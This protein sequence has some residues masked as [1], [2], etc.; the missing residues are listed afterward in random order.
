MT[1][2]AA[3][4]PAAAAAAATADFATAGAAGA[5][6][7]GSTGA[8]ISAVLGGLGSL[9]GLSAA[10]LPS[11]VQAG[12]LRALERAESMLIAARSGVLAAF[13]A[14]A[15]YQED[16]QYSARAWLTAQTRVTR[17]GGWLREMDAATG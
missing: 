15:G 9:A 7:A 2:P 12:C 1:G 4:G 14:G 13:S 3:A 10:D 6:E 5:A 16:G 11:A 17:G 8:A